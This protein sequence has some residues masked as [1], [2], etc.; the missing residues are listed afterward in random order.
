MIDFKSLKNKLSNLFFF[1]DGGKISLRFRRVLN[2]FGIFAVFVIALNSF[3]RKS[4][5]TSSLDNKVKPRSSYVPYHKPVATQTFGTGIA[6]KNTQGS[7]NAKSQ[8]P[9][10]KLKLRAPQVRLNGIAQSGKIPLGTS[11]IGELLTSIDSRDQAQLVR[12]RLPYGIKYLDE[13]LFKDSV[14]LGKAHYNQGNERIYISFFAAVD[15]EGNEFPFFAQALDSKDFSTGLIG[16]VHSNKGIKIAANVALNVISGATG[17]IQERSVGAYGIDSPSFNAENAV[18][19]GTSNAA[20]EEANGL[21][22]EL[23]SEQDYMTVE[24]G[25]EI[26]VTL[27][28]SYKGEAR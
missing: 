15:N 18:L 25:K 17:F 24:A 4:S 9:V 6:D 28:K 3:L 13:V 12:A 8:N 19:N 14:L 5:D 21:S 1:E 22:G 7:T 20:K 16:N 26:M 2:G 23:N 27:T 10:S 11:A